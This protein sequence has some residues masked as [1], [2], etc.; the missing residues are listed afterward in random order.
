MMS[1]DIS[2]HIDVT[3]P[4]VRLNSW[5]AQLAI[6]DMLDWRQIWGSGRPKKSSNVT[7]YH[8]TSCGSGCRCKAK[9]GLRR[10]PRGLHTRTRLSSLLRLNLDSSLKTTWFHS[11]AVQ[12]PRAR[13][14]SKWKR[15]WVGIKGSTR[16]G[17]HDSKCPSAMRLHM[18][19]EDTRAPSEDATC[20]WM[21]A[22]EAVICTRAFLTMWRSSRLLVCL[23]R[24]EPG[25]HVNDIS[26]IHWSQ[27]LLTT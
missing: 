23:G 6:P 9:V 5:D 8:H 4:L 11:A 2:F 22:D 3:L 21:V 7:P 25:F 20:A 24:L 13:H 19:R 1:R 27:H 10:S 12:F 18:V 26:W 16:N 14:H 17:H 15:R